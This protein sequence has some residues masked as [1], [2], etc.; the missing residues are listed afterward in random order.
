MLAT[1]PVG[2]DAATKK[3]DILTALGAHAC[4]SDPGLQRLTLRLITLVTA[5]YNWRS[6]ELSVGRRDIA[7]LW[8]VDERTVKRDFARLKAMGW[9]VVRKAGVRGRVTAY[10]LDLDAVLRATEPAWAAVGPDFVARMQALT[11]QG[12]APP[13]ETPQGNV[14]PFRSRAAEL[15]AGDGPWPRACALLLAEDAAVFQTWFA[16]L[17]VAE[18]S[19][20]RLD[21]L[22]PSRFHARYVETHLAPRLWAA[23]ARVAPGLRALRI[24]SC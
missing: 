22:A 5:R 3:Y 1:A 17:Q 12:A 24:L 13:A 23:L 16:G 4:Q 20:E 2:R 14:V 11:G 6:E 19:D 7:R 8:G 9:V 21:L 15:P 18:S 10:G